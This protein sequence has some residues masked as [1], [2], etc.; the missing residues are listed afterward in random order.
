MNFAGRRGRNR[1]AGKASFLHPGLVFLRRYLRDIISA[2]LRAQ[3]RVGTKNIGVE[4]G[5]PLPADS[6]WQLECLLSTSAGML[7]WKREPS[8]ACADADGIELRDA[9]DAP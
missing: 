9:L 7:L 1:A 2:V 5:N 6:E 4:I 8:L 3:G